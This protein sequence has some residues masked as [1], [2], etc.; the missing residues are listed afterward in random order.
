[1]R[2]AAPANPA[3][4]KP[5]GPTSKA[6][7]AAAAAKPAA[8]AM[9]A[10]GMPATMT[11]R[12]LRSFSDAETSDA[13]TPARQLL[14]GG[15][16]V[17]TWASVS[18]KCFTMAEL[19]LVAGQQYFFKVRKSRCG[20][21]CGTSVSSCF[22]AHCTVICVVCRFFWLCCRVSCAVSSMH[23]ALR[24]CKQ[25]NCK[26]LLFPIRQQCVPSERLA[27]ACPSEAAA[28]G[29][30]VPHQGSA[31]LRSGETKY[32]AAHAALTGLCT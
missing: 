29:R 4:P 28:H 15:A 14:Q 22:Y 30:F 32:T 17:S 8:A 21:R 19:G 13:V 31:E 20:T 18:D 3:S 11:T 25:L 24:S 9:P 10:G 12:G 27:L 23:R 1:M 16:D 7:A 26:Q 6:A 2:A 5:A